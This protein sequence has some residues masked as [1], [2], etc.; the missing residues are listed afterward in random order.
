MHVHKHTESQ[1]EPQKPGKTNHA[2]CTTH[3]KATHSHRVPET[4]KNHTQ[5]IPQKANKEM[6]K[7]HVHVSIIH[8]N[9][10]QETPPD[11]EIKRNHTFN[12]S[13]INLLFVF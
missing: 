12:S 7:T 8:R 4:R 6:I 5:H 13:A 2:H 9:F 3:N 11:N 10:D 1:K